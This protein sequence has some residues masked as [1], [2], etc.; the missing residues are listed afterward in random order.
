MTPALAVRTE[1]LI[2]T[3]TRKVRGIAQD[4][5]DL[6]DAIL[7]A[8]QDTDK[9]VTVRQMYYLLSVQGAVEKTDSGYGRAQRQLLEMRQLGIIPYEWIADNTRWMRKPNTYSSVEHAL[10]STRNFYRRSVWEHLDQYI[11][12]WCEKDALAGV[13]YPITEQ[14]DIPLMVTRGYSSESYAYGAAQVIKEKGKTAYIYYLG[15]FDPS[16]WQMSRNLEDKLKGFGAEIE[17]IRLAVNLE[18]IEAWKLPSRPTKK[19]DTR[20]KEFYDTFGKN[21]ESVE[22]DAIPPDDL[23]DLV[24]DAIDQHLPE[25]Y[26]DEL[27]VAEES[28][29]DILKRLEKIAA[30]AAR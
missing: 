26:L 3:S 21:T 25:G 13:L 10:R 7:D 8:F 16:G 18:Q 27:K 2:C 19:T 22:L 17:F 1:N 23:R 9:P 5:R 24:D 6:R 11:E 14:Y 4:T 29:R 12:V 15:D 28:E 20:C 30:G